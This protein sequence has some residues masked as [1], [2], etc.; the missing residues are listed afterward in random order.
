MI[1]THPGWI[2]PIDEHR[3]M[4]SLGAH[5]EYTFLS[6]MPNWA[7][8][9]IPELVNT[10]RQVGVGRCIITTGFGQWMHPPASEGMRMAI[11]TLLSGGMDSS[12]VSALVKHNPLQLVS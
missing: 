1:A 11:S 9:N 4:V 12:E 8:V 5:L 2:A 10:L 3:V 7:R 6:C